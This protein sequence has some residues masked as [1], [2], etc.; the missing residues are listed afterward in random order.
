MNETRYVR[1][2]EKYQEANSKSVSAPTLFA[3]AE[4]QPPLR[5]PEDPSG[6]GDTDDGETLESKDEAEESKDRKTPTTLVQD[7]FAKAA[8]LRGGESPELLDAMRKYYAM[9]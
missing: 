3:M 6:E 4:G 2:E 5:Y 8:E 1:L 9:K 7:E